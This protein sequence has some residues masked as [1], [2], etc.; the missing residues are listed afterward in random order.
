MPHHP[1]MHPHKRGNIRRVL[2]DAAKFHGHSLSNVLITGPDLLQS[3]VKI[4]FRF[5]LFPKAV[6]ADLDDGMFLLVGVIAKDQ[7][8]IHFLWRKDPSTEI[9]LF[10]YVRHVFGSKNSPTCANYALNRTATDNFPKVVQSVQTNSYMDEYL[11][12]SPTVEEATQ[13]ANDLVKLL[14]LGEF[15]LPKFVSNFLQQIEPNSEC[16]P[17]NGRQIPTTEE[18]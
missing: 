1:V 14:S 16:Q 10:Q 3:L 18:S 4:L 6:S 13:K 2:N 12:S 8:S 5:R 17:N 9:A 15:N 11:G 7:P